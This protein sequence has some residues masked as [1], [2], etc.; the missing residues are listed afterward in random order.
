MAGFGNSSS[1]SFL[2]FNQS[3]A[4]VQ[5][6]SIINIALACVVTATS[7][8][9][10]IILG[11]YL[12]KYRFHVQRLVLYITLT[13]F[14]RG[15]SSILNGISVLLL[16]ATEQNNSDFCRAN[17]LIINSSL[18]T[19][20]ILI[21]WVTIDLLLMVVF[22]LFTNKKMEVIQLLSSFVLPP[23]VLWVPLMFDSYGFS[24][25]I[26]GIH[27][28]D[29]DDCTH[30]KTGYIMFVIFRLVPFT[31][32]LVLIGSMYGA[33][34]AVLKKRERRSHG[35]DPKSSAEW[36]NLYKRVRAL[37]VYPMLAFLLILLPSVVQFTVQQVCH[38]TVSRIW[39]TLITIVTQNC[40]GVLVSLAFIFDG[41]TRQHLR[42]SCS[43]RL[44]FT[45]RARVDTLQSPYVSW[46]DSLKTQ[47]RNLNLPEHSAFL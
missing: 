18:W 3:L 8:T 34:L 6:V 4:V 16:V 31:M 41:E 47:K 15:L 10:I 13:V 25:G 11:F 1:E 37:A 5:A 20:L 44:C 38:L 46:S 28:P 9:A 29:Y 45:K 27:P 17:G 26:C 12:K 43:M 21:W 23:L 2:C 33:V 24:D 14:L 39:L 36:I 7:F 35:I 42:H 30:S 19:E 32:L 22:S 40:G